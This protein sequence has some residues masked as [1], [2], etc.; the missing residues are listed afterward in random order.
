MLP[1]FIT[2]QLDICDERVCTESLSPFHHFD[3][4]YLGAF[5]KSEDIG[6]E[7]STD[8]IEIRL[9]SILALSL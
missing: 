6:F 1:M 7:S 3:A 2:D 8:L 5:D 4:H 9:V